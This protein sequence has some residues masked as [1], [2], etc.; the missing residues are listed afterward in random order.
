MKT[1]LFVH[2][3]FQNSKSWNQWINY[4]EQ[5]GY[6]CIAPSW[7]GHE[8]VPAAL[9]ADPPKDLGDLRL[10]EVVSKMDGITVL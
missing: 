8:G 3:M 10:E 7:R 2:G 1:I 4:F 9:R 6:D 5:S